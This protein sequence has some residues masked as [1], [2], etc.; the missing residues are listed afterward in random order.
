MMYFASPVRLVS[1]YGLSIIM[2]TI[3]A[4][5][6]G[7]Y[8]DSTSVN[9]TRDSYYYYNIEDAIRN[10][11]WYTGA[12]FLI[13]D[14]QNME[15]LPL[16]IGLVT[17]VE[18]I[19]VARNKLTSLPDTLRNCMSMDSFDASNNLL[20]NTPVIQKKLLWA[21]YSNNMISQVDTNMGIYEIKFLE[22]N[23]NNISY[24]P[25]NLRTFG[26]KDLIELNLRGNPLPKSELDKIRALMP[27]TKVLF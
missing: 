13:L 27:N 19:S 21:R 14:N 24:W 18:M 22:L 7:C 26:G 17:T 3:T 25:D 23:D 16:R 11:Y 15:V 9:K 20:K 5:I 8:D 4:I 10:E 6:Y 1:R 2:T 12:Q